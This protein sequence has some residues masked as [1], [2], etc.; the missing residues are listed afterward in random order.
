MTKSMIDM[1]VGPQNQRTTFPHDSPQVPVL[2][3]TQNCMQHGAC[4]GVANSYVMYIHNMPR[5]SP[6]RLR[7]K[8]CSRTMRGM[9][10]HA[11][12][13]NTPCDSPS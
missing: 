10:E 7:R 4:V 11:A 3:Y 8:P 2:R 1:T 5:D 12:C 6:S 9:R 13:E